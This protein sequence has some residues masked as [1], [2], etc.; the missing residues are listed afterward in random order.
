MARLRHTIDLAPV[1]RGQ[2]EDAVRV[3]H[4]VIEGLRPEDGRLVTEDGRTVPDA[5]LRSGEHA[6]PGAV[7]SV[8]GPAQE[9][10]GPPADR[11]AVLEWDRAVASAVRYEAER[12][13]PPSRGSAE[14]RLRSAERPTTVRLVVRGELTRPDGHRRRM[15]W[16]ALRAEVDLD[17]WWEAVGGGLG[18]GAGAGARSRPALT[19]LM[20]HPLLQATTVVVPRPG[21]DGGWRLDI[22]T[23]LRGRRLVRPVAAIPLRATRRLTHRAIGEALQRMADDWRTHAVPRITRTPDETRRA[24]LDDLAGHGSRTRAPGE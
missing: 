15:R 18:S 22:E 2:V 20:R 14:L 13:E 4:D 11:L 16:F 9:G 10:T 6:R 23:T 24:L 8:P 19:V 21:K 12:P 17:R 1:A 7:Y 3:L 5:V